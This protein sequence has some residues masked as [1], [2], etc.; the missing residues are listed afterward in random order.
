MPTV[1]FIAADGSAK[2]QPATSR[3]RLDKGVFLILESDRKGKVESLEYDDSLRITMHMGGKEQYVL[4]FEDAAKAAAVAGTFKGARAKKAPVSRMS[5]VPSPAPS[6][7][8]R[9]SLGSSLSHHHHHRRG[10]S[11]LSDFSSTNT[12]PKIGGFSA[13]QPL[14]GRDRTAA[15][16]AAEKVDKWRHGTGGTV[17]PSSSSSSGKPRGVPDAHPGHKTPQP[18]PALDEDAETPDEKKRRLFANVE[19]LPSSHTTLGTRTTVIRRAPAEPRGPML[20]FEPRRGLAPQSSAAYTGYRLTENFGLRN[21]GNTCY[22]NA[23]MQAFSSLREF[24]AELR[25]MPASIPPCQDGAL[26]RCSVEMLQQMSSTGAGRGPLSPGK[27]REQIAVASP[28]FG[29]NEQQDAHEFLLEYTNQLH[30]ELLSARNVFLPQDA[31]LEQVERCQLATH[32]HL[33]SEVQKR[34]QCVNCS[35]A[36]VLQ[37]RFRDFSIDFPADDKNNKCALASMVRSYFAPEELEAR[38]DHCGSVAAHMEKRLTSPPRTLVLHL[39]RFVPNLEKR[40]YDKRHQSVDF[41]ARF[42]LQE[43]L[44]GSSPAQPSVASRLPARPLARHDSLGSAEKPHAQPVAP[45]SPPMWYNLR[46]LVAH[47]G[48]SPQAG[49][50]VCYA[51]GEQ[52]AWR[53]YDDSLVKEMPVGF[54]PQLQLGQRAYILFYVLEAPEV[55]MID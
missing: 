30:D 40:R 55:T 25:A 21:L 27:L 33:D 10:Y 46:S 51:K 6:G 18:R 53:L 1:T 29:R 49:H 36:R 16:A 32:V 14:P 17:P 44:G 19:T 23:V 43:C 50:Y 47:D 11:E 37:E 34:L 48:A 35:H 13:G 4:E 9:A 42:D 38:C 24:V 45:P 28:M 22:L 12:L 20:T 7:S 41:P 15:Q 54:D 2:E 39:K 5:E 52:G 31:E 8:S 26:F 3:V